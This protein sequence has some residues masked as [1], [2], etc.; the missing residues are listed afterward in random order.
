MCSVG[1]ASTTRS[2]CSRRKFQSMHLNKNSWVFVTSRRQ[3]RCVVGELRTLCDILDVC[4]LIEQYI[5]MAKEAQA[6]RSSK[7]KH[8]SHSIKNP[9]H[10]SGSLNNCHYGRVGH[11]EQILAYAAGGKEKHT[12]KESRSL[13]ADSP[14]YGIQHWKNV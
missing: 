1:P 14:D 13:V 4:R 7:D 5:H 12:R 11:D 6:S 9:W 10:Q 8:T 3:K 2:A